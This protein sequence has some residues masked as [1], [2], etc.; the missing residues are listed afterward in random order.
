VETV[1]PHLAAPASEQ[2][3][4]LL[5]EGDGEPA[6]AGS[7]RL[8]RVLHAGLDDAGRLDDQVQMIVLDRELDDLERARVASVALPVEDAA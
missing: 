2:L 4:E 6:H 7:Q 3:G 5:R 1:A 8:G